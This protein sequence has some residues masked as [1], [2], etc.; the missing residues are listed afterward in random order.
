MRSQISKFKDMPF[1]FQRAIV[2]DNEENSDVKWT[3][4]N[5]VDWI[6]DKEKVQIWIEDYAKVY[7]HKEFRVGEISIEELKDRIMKC[8][9]FDFDDFEEYHNWYVEVGDIPDYKDSVFPV[10]LSD[11]GEC[12]E[13]GWHRFHSYIRNKLT[14]IPFVEYI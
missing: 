1:N 11:C 12:I 10:V 6:K 5:S 9:C 13:D 2:I 4:F 8:N 3:K 7:L 14:K